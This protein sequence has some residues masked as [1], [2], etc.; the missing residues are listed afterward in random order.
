MGKVAVLGMTKGE[1][2]D[3]KVKGTL[4]LVRV[5]CLTKGKGFKGGKRERRAF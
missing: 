3:Q 5:I 2:G 1:K 4:F